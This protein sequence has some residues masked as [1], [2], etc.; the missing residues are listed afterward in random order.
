MSKKSISHYDSEVVLL[1]EAS[2]ITLKNPNI[3]N[4]LLISLP[5]NQAT[6]GRISKDI[7]E[8]NSM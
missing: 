4:L 2:L 5:G 3:N 7:N 6:C 8:N 1:A